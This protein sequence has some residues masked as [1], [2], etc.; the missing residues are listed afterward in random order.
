MVALGAA[1]LSSDGERRR[2]QLRGAIDAPLADALTG[3]HKGKL[4]EQVAQQ[5]ERHNALVAA[6]QAPSNRGEVFAG[7]PRLCYRAGSRPSCSTRRATWRST[8]CRRTCAP[9]RWRA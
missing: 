3:A 9:S 6:A 4:R 8:S 5:I 7:V 1:T 2:V